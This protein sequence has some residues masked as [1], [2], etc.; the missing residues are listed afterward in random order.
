MAKVRV[1]N[2][3]NYL[4]LAELSNGVVKA[5]KPHSFF[6]L[7]QD[8]V[9]ILAAT[10][11]FFSNGH[12]TIEDEKVVEEIGLTEEEVK[13]LSDDDIKKIL[14]GKVADFHKFIDE[15]VGN[16][17]M[18]IRIREIAEK[19]DLPASKIKYMNEK[20]DIDVIAM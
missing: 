15:S 9:E 19:E 18:I 4:V 2:P 3:N 11:S 17:S 16:L 12:L 6:V 1:K 7:D 13:V 14:K 8:E 5:F 10:T 20:L